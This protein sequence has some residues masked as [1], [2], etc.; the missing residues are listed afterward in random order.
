VDDAQ[1][2][3]EFKKKKKDNNFKDGKILENE[4]LKTKV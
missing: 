4:I 1:G 2:R 3:D